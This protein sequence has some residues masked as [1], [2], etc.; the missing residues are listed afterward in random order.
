MRIGGLEMK[1]KEESAPS[2]MTFFVLGGSCSVKLRQRKEQ[3]RAVCDRHVTAWRHASPLKICTDASCWRQ[4]K[5][6][7][8]TGF[9]MLKFGGALLGKVGNCECMHVSES[10]FGCNH[11][12]C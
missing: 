6:R 7:F 3:K 11:N 12:F 5:Q 8:V 4:K 2:C 10:R 9:V 1:E